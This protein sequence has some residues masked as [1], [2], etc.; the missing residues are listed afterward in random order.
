MSGR[1]NTE[2]AI[3]HVRAPRVGVRE[4]WS[5][6]SE[7]KDVTRRDSIQVRQDAAGCNGW[8]K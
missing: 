2:R 6:D 4:Y 7:S 5:E 8:R 1:S 3:E